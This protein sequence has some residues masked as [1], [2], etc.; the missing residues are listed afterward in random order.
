MK[1]NLGFDYIDMIS[2]APGLDFGLDALL[3]SFGLIKLYTIVDGK[4]KNIDGGKLKGIDDVISSRVLV[5][6]MVIISISFIE[7]I[8]LYKLMLKNVVSALIQSLFRRILN[9]VFILRRV[10]IPP[11]TGHELSGKNISPLTLAT[12]TM[13]LFCDLGGSICRRKNPR[14]KSPNILGQ[15]LQKIPLRLLPFCLQDRYYQTNM[16]QHS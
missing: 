4:L 16:Y 14:K 7:C 5:V 2:H 15:I 12:V 11:Q 1:L 13:T 3:K 6:A 8:S 9:I 10:N